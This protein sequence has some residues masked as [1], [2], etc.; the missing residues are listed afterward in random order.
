MQLRK[1]TL[2]PALVLALAAAGATA[3]DKVGTVKFETSCSPAVQPEFERA[4]AMLHSFWFSASTD[5][6]V[7]ITQKDPGCAMAQWA[8]ALN[9]LGNP[10]GWPP[11]PKALG[12]G[13]AAIA[14][15]KTVGAK[16]QR[17]RDYIAALET[18]YRDADTSEPRPP[19][20]P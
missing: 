2:L 5:A 11:A 7:V 6:F 14:R 18:F 3:D 15:A 16:T 17:E 8:V 10:F 13:A 12:D 20:H 4:V 9:L 1:L 19:P